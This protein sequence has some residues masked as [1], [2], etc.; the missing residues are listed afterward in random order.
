VNRAAAIAVAAWLAAGCGGTKTGPLAFP[1]DAGLSWVGVPVAPGEF[2]VAGIP[3]VAR[4]AGEPAVFLAVAPVDPAEARG[5]T[6]RYAASSAAAG[7]IGSARGWKPKAWA[8]HRVRGF[9]VPARSRAQVVV[10]VSSDRRRTIFIHRFAIE[11]RVGDN[12]YRAVYPV[13]IKACVGRSS[14]SA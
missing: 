2:A 8:L 9:E 5:A 3:L 4:K 10:G 6:I 7:M 12:R 11:Y 1:K 13:G 14:C